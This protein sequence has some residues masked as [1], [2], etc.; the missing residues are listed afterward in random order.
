M[1]KDDKKLAASNTIQG[2][3]TARKEIIRVSDALI[4][5]LEGELAEAEATGD[6]GGAKAIAFII[7]SYDV[8]DLALRAT[9]EQLSQFVYGQVRGS[10]KQRPN[11]KVTVPQLIKSMADIKA[12]ADIASKPIQLFAG[13]VRTQ[14]EQEG[15]TEQQ[16]LFRRLNAKFKDADD[17]ESQRL[18]RMTKS[19]RSGRAGDTEGDDS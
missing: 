2:V 9:N 19:F 14:R 12:C 11:R 18:Q 13:V 16:D 17:T 3:K 7:R 8:W 5:T 4:D 15:L 1:P 10:D 6:V